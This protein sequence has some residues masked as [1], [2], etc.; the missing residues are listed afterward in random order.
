MVMSNFFFGFMRVQESVPVPLG[1]FDCK[2][3]TRCSFEGWFL[4]SWFIL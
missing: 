4:Y 1:Y 2:I 3:C